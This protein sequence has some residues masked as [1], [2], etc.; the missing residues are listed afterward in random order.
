MSPIYLD[1]NATTPLD[2]R[3][4]EAM[5][6]FF[7]HQFGNA[8]SSTH[9]YGWQAE[10]AVR[11]AREQIAAA[12]GAEPEELVFTSGSTESNNLAL[13][14]VAERYAR[15]GDHLITLATEHKAVL[16]VCSYLEQIGKRVTMLPVQEN[17][18]V[19]LEALENAM[20]DATVLVSVML[21][22]NETGVIQP[23]KAISEIVHRHGSLLHTDATQAPGK[24]AFDV[25]DL[26]V[27]LVSLSAHKVYGP[28]GVGA[29]YVRRK[30]PR[31]SLSPIIHGGG[32]ERG[33]RSG[34]LN[35][36]GIVGFGKAMALAQAEL[37]EDVA[38][39][40]PLRDRLEQALLDLP[41]TQVN[42]SGAPRLPN[43]TNVSFG[44]VNADA[45]LMAMRRIAVSTGSACTSALIEPSHVL[46]A[47]GISDDDAYAS[48]RFSLGRF[49]TSEDIDTAIAVVQA[50][51]EKLRSR[52]PA[53][54]A[55][56][57]RK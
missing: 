20:N 28:K 42:G 3:V 1:Y 27:D 29:L 16:D 35:V 22:N 54:R 25:Q 36:P 6:P 48:I 9:V 49:T 12:I 14:G 56:Q 57:A 45:L 33:H 32:H 44:Y 43:V 15:K 39:I 38:R 41:E 18:L 10:E 19:E 13:K 37:S 21:A 8:A 24:L 46:A 2:E 31:V 40:L 7:K 34:T 52:N 53:W 4:L 30:R 47:M 26:G 50:A 11:I 55:L 23:L 5:L 51:I 17:G